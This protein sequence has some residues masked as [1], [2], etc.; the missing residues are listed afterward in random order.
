M[1]SVKPLQHRRRRRG[2]H[3]KEIE[4]VNLEESVPPKVS[5]P[6]VTLSE[7][8][9]AKDTATKFEVMMRCEK[10]LSVTVRSRGELQL[11]ISIK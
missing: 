6:L 10:R 4:P 8:V 3:A 11:K 2:T 5:S 9:G 1:K 7:L